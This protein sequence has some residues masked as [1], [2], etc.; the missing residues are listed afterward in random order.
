MRIPSTITQQVVTLDVATGV[1]I[2]NA[3]SGLAVYVALTAGTVDIEISPD[4]VNW[5]PHTVGVGASITPVPI[6]SRF[7]RV[8]TNTAVT[9]PIIRWCAHLD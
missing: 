5:Y 1:D 9:A 3:V 4:G 8:M 7:L 2:T 6:A